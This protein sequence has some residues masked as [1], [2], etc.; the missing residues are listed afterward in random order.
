MAKKDKKKDKGEGKQGPGKLV[1]LKKVLFTILFLS[2]FAVYGVVFYAISG[3]KNPDLFTVIGAGVVTTICG[4]L[5]QSVFLNRER[6]SVRSDIA[7]Y[8]EEYVERNIDPGL[9]LLVMPTIQFLMTCYTAHFKLGIEW[10][11]SGGAGLGAG[12]IIALF[13]FLYNRK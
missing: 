10:L 1:I 5:M 4:T 6:A 9:G 8:G 12:A 3:T 2:G 11:E 13:G 7:K